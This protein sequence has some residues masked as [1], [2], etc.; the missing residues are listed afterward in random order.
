MD[1]NNF[2]RRAEAA[3]A[4]AQAAQAA[5]AA[6]AAAAAAEA[7]AANNDYNN[8]DPNNQYDPRMAQEP[9]LAEAGHEWDDGYETDENEDLRR[10]L[11]EIRQGAVDLHRPFEEVEEG[12]RHIRQDN[13]YD[14]DEEIARREQGIPY[15]ED[16]VMQGGVRIT[17]KFPDRDAAL[18]HFIQNSKWS[19][20][21][22]DSI[23]CITLVAAL[24]ANITNPYR[25]LRNQN[26]N[27]PVEKI[28]IKLFITTPT[29]SRRS[30]MI[31]VPGRPSHIPGEIELTPENIFM[32]EI[33]TQRVIYKK[34]FLDEASFLEPICPKIINYVIRANLSLF[35][36]LRGMSSQEQRQLDDILNASR[37]HGKDISF[38]VMEMMEG[39]R[40]AGDV[41]KYTYDF[42]NDDKRHLLDMIQ[43]EF[44]RL[45]EYGYFHGD[46]HFGNVMINGSYKNYIEGCTIPGRAIIIDFGRTKKLPAGRPNHYGLERWETT[47]P[48]DVAMEKKTFDY[49]TM[50]I[51]AAN[52][53]RFIDLKAF[54]DV[55][56][57]GKGIEPT[58]ISIKSFFKNLIDTDQRYWMGG[59]PSSKSK[60]NPFKTK[61]EVFKKNLI[62][63]FDDEAN[64]E[65]KGDL[66]TKD[67][68]QKNGELK[69]D[70]FT[71]DNK[72]KNGELKGELF[73]Q[74]IMKDNKQQNRMQMIGARNLRNRSNNSRKSKRKL[75]NKKFM[76]KHSR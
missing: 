38:V 25:S 39:Y 57:Q 27:T 26:F 48:P 65:L 8:D 22:N 20:L 43:Y 54:L 31:S 36:R 11:D 59:G 61:F 75:K 56:G 62:A 44:K 21:T 9:G 16:D 13:G 12:R 74:D 34:S 45:N 35:Q 29:A 4:A 55:N 64:G 3:A 18:M 70:L 6:A 42:R 71:K 41:F 28:L 30:S 73:I 19:L 58:Y 2:R 68:K 7:A 51:K 32:D 53:Q 60:M 63:T 15:G 10:R 24:K 49:Y 17:T 72:Q 69:G 14:T 33:R 23:S 52:Q 40:I 5:Q 1:R 76:T 66:F 46:S 50:V 67:N 37:K 47:V